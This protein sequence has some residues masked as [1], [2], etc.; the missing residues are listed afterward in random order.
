MC[1]LVKGL[2]GELGTTVSKCTEL[3]CSHNSDTYAWMNQ[4]SLEEDLKNKTKQ[5]VLCALWGPHPHWACEIVALE[6]DYIGNACVIA[7]H[8]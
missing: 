5:N 6:C 4:K 3:V 1:C 8:S 2:L 7:P